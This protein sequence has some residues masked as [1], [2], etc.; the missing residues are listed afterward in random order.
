LLKVALN[1]INPPTHSRIVFSL[2][3]IIQYQYFNKH[4]PIYFFR[5]IQF[6]IQIR[7]NVWKCL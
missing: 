7:K 2:E 3:N 4:V 6:S 1:T 5:T